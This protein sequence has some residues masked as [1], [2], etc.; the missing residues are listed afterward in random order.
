M[1]VLLALLPDTSPC[2]SFEV[3]AVGLTIHFNAL[4]NTLFGGSAYKLGMVASIAE[5]DLRS[6]FVINA[7]RASE[8]YGG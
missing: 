4:R 7:Y 2:Y 8:R 1:S 3:D 6:N 5:S